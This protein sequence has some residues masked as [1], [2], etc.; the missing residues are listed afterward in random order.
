MSIKICPKCNRASNSKQFRCIH[1]G[2]ALSTQNSPNVIVINAP[3][4]I[5][6]V[7]WWAICCWPAAYIRLGQ[8]T[9]GIVVFMVAIVLTLVTGG[10]IAPLVWIATI[11]DLVMCGTYK[12]K[13]GYIEEWD[14]FKS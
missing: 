10:L 11:V 8:P 6:L 5:E 7:L 14:F 2:E 3:S 9:K 12:I 1:C 13:H 4:V